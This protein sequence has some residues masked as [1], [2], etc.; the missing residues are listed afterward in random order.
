MSTA[1]MPLPFSHIPCV[2]LLLVD[3]L[4]PQQALLHRGLQLH[5]AVCEV[6]EVEQLDLLQLLK[7]R[8]DG[9]HLLPT[10]QQQKQQEQQEAAALELKL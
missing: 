7:P 4:Y 6:G 8:Q 2:F 1:I 9:L 3:L 10:A 5:A